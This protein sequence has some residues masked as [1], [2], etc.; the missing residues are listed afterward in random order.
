M[1]F[2]KELKKREGPYERIVEW[3][4]LA[5]KNLDII[6]SMKIQM[7]FIFRWIA[8]NGLYSVSYEMD[9]GEKKAEKAQ[10]WKKVEA[11]CDKFILTDKNLSSQIYS[12]EA[13]KIFF[14]NIKEKSNYMGKYLYDLKSARTKEEQAKYL[15]M[16]AYKIR[17]RLFHGEKN[18]SLDANQ[19]VV[20][21]ATKIINPILNYVIT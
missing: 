1:S 18:P 7:K 3:K 13:K 15:V 5:N 9:N 2:Q 21:T 10:E 19:L 17:C 11:F 4:T 14:D 16:I 20:E 8:F 12:A 6:L